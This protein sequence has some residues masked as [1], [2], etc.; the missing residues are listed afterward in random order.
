MFDEPRQKPGLPPAE[1]IKRIQKA[2]RHGGD[3]HTWEDVR[4]GIQDGRLRI[5]HDEHGCWIVDL[6]VTPQKRYLS[7][8]IVAGQLPEV[9]SLQKE[10]EKYAEEQGCA[11]MRAECRPGWKIV[12]PQYG[13]HQT[14]IVIEKEIS[15]ER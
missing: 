14:G 2:L 3:T 10:V 13:W 12:Y 4:E 7:C 1:I 8:W 5:F 6:I 11:F 15:H 9:M